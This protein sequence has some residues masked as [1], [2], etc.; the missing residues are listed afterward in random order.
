MIDE[1]A[2]AAGIDD[3]YMDA[4]TYESGPSYFDI[5]SGL[6]TIN[7]G[8][9]AFSKTAADQLIEASHE[10]AHAQVFNKMSK[11]MGFDATFQEAFLNPERNFG[12]PLYA[13]EEQLVERLARWRVRRHS[14]GLSPQQEAAST[15]YIDNWKLV[16]WTLKNMEREE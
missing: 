13:R 8:S 12:R 2:R 11:S 6:R 10:I 3:I 5:L 14:G 15:K 4:V 1:A 9:D 16:E 7:I